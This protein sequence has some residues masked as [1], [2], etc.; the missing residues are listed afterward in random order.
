MC[1]W[2]GE[3]TDKQRTAVGPRLGIARLCGFEERGAH[4]LRIRLLSTLEL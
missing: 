2:N 1:G 4:H 3:P